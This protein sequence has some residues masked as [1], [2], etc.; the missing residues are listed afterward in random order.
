M[1]IILVGG[2]FDRDGGHKSYIVDCIASE[3]MQYD[4]TYVT[5]FNGGH[6]SE[7]MSMDMHYAINGTDVLLWMPNVD[8]AEDKI[9][10]SIKK[11]WPHLT[12][13]QSKNV[14]GRD[15][16]DFRLVKRLLDSHSSLGIVFDKVSGKRSYRIL[17]PLGN[18]WIETSSVSALSHAL[19]TRLGILIRVQRVGSRSVEK[20]SSFRL[21]DEFLHSVKTLGEQFTEHVMA[22]NPDRYLGNAS[23]RCCHGFPSAR[24]GNSIYVSQRNV[25]KTIIT[26][27][28]FV[29]VYANLHDCIEYA[30]DAKPS[31]DTPIQMRLYAIYSRVNYMVHGHVYVKDAPY[32]NNCIP[33]GG[34]DEV[35]DIVTVQPNVEL[36]D[37]AVNLRG[38]GCLICSTTPQGLL[39]YELMPRGLLEDQSVHL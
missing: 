5:V 23:T 30:G 12:L 3:L 24:A 29:E 2:T 19:F 14:E 21:E 18:K 9:L 11:T 27:Q 4:I 35:R 6:I 26:S 31:V 17:D 33:C 32:T 28:Q 34:L 7:L 13:V 1:K 16:N 39:D 37:F 15:T 10:P 22:A 8:N 20:A 25:D 38:H 36:G